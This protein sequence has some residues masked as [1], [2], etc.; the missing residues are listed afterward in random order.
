MLV[1]MVDILWD[2]LGITVGEALATVVAASVLFWVF[3]A[4]MSSFGQRRARVT[5]ASLA[6]MTVIGAVTARAMLGPRPTLVTGLLVLTVLLVWERVVGHRLP[7]PLAS[8]SQPR[9][10]LRDGVIDEE[11][12]KK[13]RL[14]STDLIV[15]LRHKGITRLQDVAF[16]IVEG[17][18]SITVIRAGQPVGEEFLADVAGA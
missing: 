7:R 2:Q 13:V 15:R 12:L 6:L 16:A 8:A 14:R 11:A 1:S 5:A 3:A 9:V 4:L 17:E 18:G 10:V